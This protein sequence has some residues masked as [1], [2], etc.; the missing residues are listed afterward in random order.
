MDTDDPLYREFLDELDALDKFRLAYASIRPEAGLQAED[1]DVRRIIEALALFV[2]R[3]RQASSRSIDQTIR[4]MFQQHFAY[5][6]DPM[7]CM[8]MLEGRPGERLADAAYLPRGTR[9]T[10]TLRPE[11]NDREGSD[12]TVAFCTSLGLRVL[13]IVL[14]DLE[15]FRRPHGGFRM[16]FRFESGFFRNDEI[17]ELSLFVNHLGDFLASLEVVHS[18]KH[19]LQGA[20][21]VFQDI[22]DTESK[23]QPLEVS[24]GA[25]HQQDAEVLGFDHPLQRVRSSFHFPSQD[26]FVNFRVRDQPRNWESFAIYLDLHEGWPTHLRLSRDTFRLH[27]VPVANLERAHAEPLEEDG[28]RDRHRLRNPDVDGRFVYHSLVGAYQIGEEALLPLM[29][30]V[31]EEADDSFE[32][33]TEGGG[34]KRRA[35]LQ[36]HVPSA[37]DEP[38]R[39]T[40]DAYWHQP[41]RCDAE[42]GTAAVGLADRN[43]D[44]ASWGLVGTVALPADNHAVGDRQSLLQLLSIKNQRFL[45]RNHLV[46]LM[47][48]VG[49]GVQ[50]YFDVLVDAVYDVGVESKPYGRGNRGFKYIYRVVYRNLEQGQLPAL[51]L[52]SAKMLEI[53]TAWSIEEI[54][55][56]H[57]SVPNLE[58]ELRYE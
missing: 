43:V 28:T 18:L 10:A 26:L 47:R 37:F 27:T 39:L 12:R 41:S 6:C 19:Q 50:S 5:L 2:A 49:A 29:P 51:D 11:E 55:E 24:F 53:L 7:P 56:L 34:E 58:T 1:P 40:V 3:G 13:P 8:T 35:Y 22:V 32:V 33:E 31:I 9:A 17:G 48:A 16:V 57:V 23:G 54:V 45:D 15:I 44:G 21:I 42:M 20:G 36:A 46:L 14:D 25:P 52:L 4:R 38:T 30:G